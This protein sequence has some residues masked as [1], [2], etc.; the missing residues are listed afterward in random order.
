MK[1]NNASIQKKKKMLLVLE[2][3]FRHSVAAVSPMFSH[4][5]V[6]VKIEMI[7]TWHLLRRHQTWHLEGVG[8]A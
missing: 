3:E 5:V 2:S 8:S 4:S 6:F 7:S 1:K